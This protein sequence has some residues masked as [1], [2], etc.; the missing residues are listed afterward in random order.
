M[1]D[2]LTLAIRSI[3]HTCGLFQLQEQQPH[4]TLGAEHG[5]EYDVHGHS[6]AS[7]MLYIN[8]PY[9]FLDCHFTL[10][11][12]HGVKICQ[13]RIMSLEICDKKI[14]LNLHGA[15]SNIILG[16]NSNP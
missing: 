7:N 6:V 10:D 11:V 16:E 4:F 1:L 13:K 12:I 5:E 14:I 15:M 2:K 8:T 9:S 3:P